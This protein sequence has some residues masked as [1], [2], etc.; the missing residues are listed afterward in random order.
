Y[1]VLFSAAQVLAEPAVALIDQLTVDVDAVCLDDSTGM[2]AVVGRAAGDG[3][4]DVRSFGQSG[5]EIDV[6]LTQ[7]VVGKPC[8]FSPSHG[9]LAAQG[10][11]HE[12]GHGATNCAEVEDAAWVLR[13]LYSVE[14]GALDG[15]FD[16]VDGC[17]EASLIDLEG[18]LFGLA[19]LLN[20]LFIVG[21]QL[22]VAVG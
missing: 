13:E 22:G 20:D 11:G 18:R 21:A 19:D 7:L 12:I 5:G 9:V 10:I 8:S 4:V 16:L 1:G 2:L 15:A 14:G 3:Q 6:P 17:V